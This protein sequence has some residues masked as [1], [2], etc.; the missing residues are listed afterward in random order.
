MDT[1]NTFSPLSNP[2][3]VVGHASQEN[4]T[5][6]QTRASEPSSAPSMPFG[7]SGTRIRNPKIKQ[8]HQPLPDLYSLFGPQSH[9][10][11]RYLSIRFKEDDMNDLEFEKHIIRITGDKEIT[12]HTDKSNNKIIKAKDSLTS[13]KV[14]ELQQLG[15]LPVEITPHK[16]LNSRKGT[17]L[18]NHLRLKDTPFTSAGPSIKESLE[19]R[20]HQIEEVVTYE[21]PSRSRRSNL[22]LARVT[23]H[24]QSL[25][26]KV[27]VGGVSLAVKEYVPKPMQCK[28]CW[29]FR[30]S[31]KY[32]TN[33]ET[34]VKCGQT[35]HS[36]PHCKNKLNCTNC[37]MSHHAN[38]RECVHFKY[39]CTITMMWE[40]MGLPF[41][42]AKQRIR[43]EGLFPSLTYAGAARKHHLAQQNKNRQQ[44]QQKQ[45]EFRHQTSDDSFHSVYDAG[46]KTIIGSSAA[47]TLISE[48]SAVASTSVPT[49]ATPPPPLPAKIPSDN[50]GETYLSMEEASE[51]LY[52]E[53]DHPSQD[54][55]RRVPVKSSKK[56]TKETAFT[57]SQEEN[58][59]AKRPAREENTCGPVLTSSPRRKHKLSNTSQEDQV[60]GTPISPLSQVQALDKTGAI[61]K[62][63]TQ[64]KRVPKISRERERRTDGQHFSVDNCGCHSCIF[65]LAIIKNEI[66]RPDRKFSRRFLDQGKKLKIH[67]HTSLT[68]HPQDCICKMHI[69]KINYKTKSTPP[70]SQ[71]QEHTPVAENKVSNLRSHFEEKEVRRVDPRTGQPPSLSTV[72]LNP[73][74]NKKEESSSQK[75]SSIPVV[76]SR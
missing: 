59:E 74:G 22:R 20:G 10:W 7:S 33:V 1:S 43:E 9:Q 30:H 32:C 58:P 5:V 72:K 11:D 69:E 71:Q 55:P 76:T 42:E 66:I 46:D 49:T 47:V 68:S 65:R 8:K 52:S 57:P 16:T 60:D 40:N 6:G 4:K 24:T 75:S 67:H 31:S 48:T 28:H 36:N 21:I 38:A 14:Q 63:I 73:N 61:P 25:P 26:E 39:H 27:T 29:R 18:C 70:K 35:G 53:E 50:F 19:A 34:C 62:E 41:R 64:S 45:Q 17:I 12:F 51:S 3:L 2:E 23:F 13:E 56:R 44:Q 54:S 37:G 15:E